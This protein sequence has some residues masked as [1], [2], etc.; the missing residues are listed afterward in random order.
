MTSFFN[1]RRFIILAVL[2]ATCLAFAILAVTPRVNAPIVAEPDAMPVRT[3]DSAVARFHDGLNQKQF[4]ATCEVADRTA[5]RGVSGLGCPEF[6]D[7]VRARLG[8]ALHRRRSQ[9]PLIENAPAGRPVRVGLS[10]TTRFER[11]TATERFEWRVAD[12]KA[13]LTSYSVSADAL[14][15]NGGVR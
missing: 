14:S 13:M 5:F 11:D 15:G 6:L 10:Y 3:A 9:L 2:G 7:Y 12:G 8:K 1:R 4:E